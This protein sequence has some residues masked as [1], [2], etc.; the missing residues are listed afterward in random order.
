MELLPLFLLQ[1]I[2]AVRSN[3][4]VIDI[5]DAFMDNNRII[6][7]LSLSI[8]KYYLSVI[9]YIILWWL[10]LYRTEDHENDFKV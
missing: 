8:N 2:K 3:H 1:V 4:V 10:T 5:R 9:N 6:I 7:I